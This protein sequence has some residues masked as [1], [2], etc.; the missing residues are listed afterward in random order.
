M[1]AETG[2]CRVGIALHDD[3]TCADAVNLGA[4]AHYVSAGE[5]RHAMEGGSPMNPALPSVRWQT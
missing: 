2:G 4:A 3:T 5:V 1:A